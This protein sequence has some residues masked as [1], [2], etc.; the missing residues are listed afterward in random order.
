M[1][2]T[3]RKYPVIF[4]FS[5]TFNYTFHTTHVLKDLLVSINLNSIAT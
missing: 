4:F 1:L 3:F 2:L 5:K